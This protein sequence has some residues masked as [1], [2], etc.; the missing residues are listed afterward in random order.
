MSSDSESE[1]LSPNVASY[2]NRISISPMSDTVSNIAESSAMGSRRVSGSAQRPKSRPP[3]PVVHLGLL[4]LTNPDQS[5][6][7]TRDDPIL[8]G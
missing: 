7:G 8:L 1:H 3:P 4:D 6:K 2:G 5:G